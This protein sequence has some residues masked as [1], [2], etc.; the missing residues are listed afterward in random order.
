MSVFNNKLIKLVCCCL[1]CGLLIMTSGCGKE[2]S[3]GKGYLF[4]YTMVQNPQNLD[5]QIA[6]D[7]NSI[8]VI[9]NTYTGLMTKDINGNVVC[10]VADSYTVSDDGLTYVFY[11]KKDYKWYTFDNTSFD[12]TADDFVF[13]FYRLFNPEMQ[14]PYGEKFSCLKNAKAILNGSEDLTYSDV[15]VYASDKYTIT[16]LLDTPNADFLNLLT[17][18]FA[19][20]C[21]KTFFESTHSTYGLYDYSTVSNGAFYIKQWFY[22]KY[23]SDNFLTLR[24]NPVNPQYDEYSPYAIQLT[25][26]EKSTLDDVQHSFYKDETDLYYCNSLDKSS[27]DRNDVV[28]SYDISTVGLVFNTQDTQFKEKSLRNAFAYSVNR[29]KALKKSNS[30]IDLAYGIVPKSCKVYGKYYRDTISDTSLT[31]HLSQD[32]VLQNF[33]TAKDIL[34]EISDV[35]IIMENGIDSAYIKSIADEWQKLF[36]INVL[37]EPLS[38]EEFNKSVESNDYQ[39]AIYSLN[40]TDDSPYSFL[41]Y[42]LSTSENFNYSN[43][44]VDT[45]LKASEQCLNSTDVV[46]MYSQVEESILHDIVYVPL[47]Y[48]KS[49]LV[50]GTGI[51]KIEYNPF[52]YVL[53]FDYALNYNQED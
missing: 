9:S 11:L 48:N 51:D 29:E 5:P 40:S 28:T 23:G 10:G 17:Q 18:S 41:K 24:R 13:A 35:R 26:D 53:N 44:Q 15:G 19:M 37:I 47:Y 43:L 50:C 8:T 21:N 4:K 52:N 39:I 38:A 2:Q 16:F 6:V 49:Y 12:V 42:F 30:D 20:P 36:N 34:G 7:S 46:T 31:E 22:D 27:I 25:I 33:N 1:T 3:D 14:S 32:E 45:L